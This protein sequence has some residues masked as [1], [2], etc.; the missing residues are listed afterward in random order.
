MCPIKIFVYFVIHIITVSSSFTLAAE[1]AGSA[2]S[3][4]ALRTS[5]DTGASDDLVSRVLGVPGVW[6]PAAQVTSHLTHTRCPLSACDLN[7]LQILGNTWSLLAAGIS[8]AV[9]GASFIPQIMPQIRR[10]DQVV[11]RNQNGQNS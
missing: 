10:M 8:S 11:F 1:V 5:D 6:W 2:A 4:A 9:V 7:L 3:E